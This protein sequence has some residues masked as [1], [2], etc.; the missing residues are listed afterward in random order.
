MTHFQKAD[1]GM[2]WEAQK[3]WVSMSVSNIW[4]EMEIGKRK[5]CLYAARKVNK[6]SIK[7][8]DSRES[9]NSTSQNFDQ[10]RD[11]EWIILSTFK[12]RVSQTEKKML[13]PKKGEW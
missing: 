3:I 4:N 9:D 13:N 8:D 12:S 7:W 11:V 10:I 2:E 5:R 1:H 6:Y